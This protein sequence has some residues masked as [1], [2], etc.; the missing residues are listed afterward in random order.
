MT[1]SCSW[2]VSDSL[3]HKSVRGL[4]YPATLDQISSGKWTMSGPQNNALEEKD[5]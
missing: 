5:D 4:K 2:T 1:L 3:V